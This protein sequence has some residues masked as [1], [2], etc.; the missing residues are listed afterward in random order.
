MYAVAFLYV[1]LELRRFG[2]SSRMCH[3][4]TFIR[5]TLS[6]D[7]DGIFS[8][9]KY[10]QSTPETARATFILNKHTD[11]R[12]ARP[13]PR[14]PGPNSPKLPRSELLGAHTWSHAAYTARRHASA[15]MQAH[16]LSAD[17]LIHV[18]MQHYWATAYRRLTPRTH[19]P[20]HSGSHM[21]SHPP[22]HRRYILH[23]QV[24]AWLP[25]S[26][27]QPRPNSRR[28]SVAIG[29]HKGPHPSHT[30]ASAYRNKN[31][32]SENI[33]GDVPRHGLPLNSFCMPLRS[34]F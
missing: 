22:I 23:E 13:A 29:R 5:A 19:A 33:S 20:C 1:A 21:A 10:I 24:V 3:V 31:K 2:R 12:Y 18:P 17:L 32:T 28:R 26:R 9:T 30:T 14:T 15:S 6:L 34:T 16:G 25:Q 11:P 4:R 27:S 7:Q 8:P